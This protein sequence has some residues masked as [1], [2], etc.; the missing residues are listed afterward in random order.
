MNT[1]LDITWKKELLSYLHF[2]SRHLL[3]G[4]ESS[5]HGN[6]YRCAVHLEIHVVPT[7]TNALFIN[8]VKSFK[9]TLK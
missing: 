1:E 9:F 8:L 5:I 3:A 6:L 4:K 7:P 2:L